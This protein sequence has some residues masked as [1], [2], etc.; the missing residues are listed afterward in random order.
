MVR[1]FASRFIQLE[2]EN[3]QLQ[4]A[5]ESSSDQLDQA[6]KLAAAAQR[7]AVKLK[8]E[9][10]QLKMKLKEEEK[11]KVEVQAQ[12][13]EK[14]DSLRKSIEALLGTAVRMVSSELM[15][16]VNS[17]REKKIGGGGEPSVGTA[18][19]RMVAMP[20]TVFLCTIHTGDENETLDEEEGEKGE[21]CGRRRGN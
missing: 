21:K 9:L 13:K 3:A 14:E 20:I 8:K 4:K 11:E 18:T 17:V 10:N 12:S 5:T 2:T 15:A 16:S 7:E 6:V 1:D 19:G